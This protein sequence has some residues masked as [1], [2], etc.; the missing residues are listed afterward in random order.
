MKNKLKNNK[1]LLVLALILIICFVLIVVALFKYFYSGKNTSKYGDR[2]EGA[3][4]YTLHSSMK[5]EIERLYEKTE[6]SSVS[7]KQNGKIVYLTIDLAEVKKIEDAKSIALKSL[8]KFTD[9]EKNFYDIQFI[10]T[11]SK[12]ESSSAENNLY[13]KMGYKNSSSS[14]VVWIKD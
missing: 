4:S 3:E 13:P 12:E 11:C 7:I 2:L 8:D 10:I 1:V 5:S 14:V 6:V 9:D